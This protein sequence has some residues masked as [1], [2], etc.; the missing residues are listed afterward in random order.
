MIKRDPELA[1]RTD[2]D[3]NNISQ[4]IYI[5]SY[6]KIFKLIITLMNITIFIASFQNIIFVII[7]TIKSKQFEDILNGPNPD[8]INYINNNTFIKNYKFET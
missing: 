1:E 7:D 5:N 6:V 3:N 2:L 8:E 4:L